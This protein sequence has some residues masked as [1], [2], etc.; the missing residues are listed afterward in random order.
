MRRRNEL[1]LE[2]LKIVKADI[3]ISAFTLPELIEA[4]L[5]DCEL[6]NLRE[7]SI[8]FY[9]NELKAF[10]KLIGTENIE[11]I[12]TELIKDKVI[13]RLKDQGNKPVSI[14]TRLRAVRAFFNFLVA[15][16]YIKENPME[17]VSM[18]KHRKNTI[19]TLST[20][21]INALLNVCN[22][23]TFVG[24][25]DYV[26]ISLILETGVRANE[27]VNIDVHDV[28][29]SRGLIRIKNSKSHLERT[30]PFQRTM[31][32]LLNRYIGIRGKLPTEKLFVTIDGLP[33]S[34]RQLQNRI[35]HYGKKANIKG[36]RCSCHTLRHT[37]AKLSVMNGANAFQLQAILGHTSLEMTKTYVNLFG[38]EVREGHKNFSPLQNIRR[39]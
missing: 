15:E 11:E 14:N 21:Q 9:R 12:T 24:Y 10:Q 26:I 13:R 28:D 36:V 20:A 19:E 39:K 2:E 25:R 3:P 16:G 4:F 5:E 23:R 38:N 37:F 33:L 27:L 29:L 30:V 35:T 8:R 6:R 7:H 1:S 17:A 34:K 32:E 22:L 31:R 18:L